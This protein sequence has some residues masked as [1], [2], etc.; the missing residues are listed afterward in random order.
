MKRTTA[1]ALAGMFVASCLGVQ[2]TG[3]EVLGAAPGATSG[4]DQ[5]FAGAPE[6]EALGPPQLSKRGQLNKPIGRK[7]ADEIAAAIG[8]SRDDAFTK[9]QYRAFI[10]GQ[11]NGCTNVAP[12][13]C[14]ADAKLVDE[15]V[16]IFTNT[17]GRPLISNDGEHRYRTVLGSY[18]LFVDKGGY[19]E[20]LANRNAPT[21][22]ANAIIEPG[23]YL[24][25]W[26]ENN[27]CTASVDALHASAYSVEL[28]YGV[29]AQQISDP[30]QLVENR[31]GG[32]TTEV[33][34]SMVPPIWI[35]N[36]ALLYILR[37]SVAA[38]MPAYWT[39]IPE[40]VADAISAD[41]EGRVLYSDV[42][43]Y[44]R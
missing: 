9:Q 33:G 41:A 38:E 43:S 39:P 35:V 18:G 34:M 30:A 20:S 25:T 12:N 29:A 6:Y 21:R 28:P 42:E 14:L 19:L 10:S 37:P 27:G 5:P 8:L 3:T 17:R 24:D 2:V 36:F 26:C 23:G 22:K 16:R 1:F 11:G 4:F 44:F 31:Q 15:S 7:R 40:E 32:V 13:P